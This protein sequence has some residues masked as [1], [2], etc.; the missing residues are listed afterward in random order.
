MNTFKIFCL[1]AVFSPVLSSAQIHREQVLRSGWTFSR[2]G[3]KPI[4]VVI[5]HDWAI[6]GEFDKENDIVRYETNRDGKTETVELTGLTGALPWI[7]EGEYRTTFKVSRP[8]THAELLFDGAMA[9]PEVY[10]NGSKAG[11]WAYGYNAFRVDATPFVTSD[12]KANTLTVKLRNVGQSS[13]W[14][15]GS[16]LYR[17]VKLILSGDNAID[18]WG[19]CVTTPKVSTSEAEVH[20]AV[21]LREGFS[22]GLR[23]EISVL[24]EKG[25]EVARSDAGFGN[26]GSVK[27]AVSLKFPHL[28]SPESPYLYTLRTRVIKDGKTVDENSTRFGVRW[29]SFDKEHG[30][31]FNGATRKIKGVCLHHDLGPLGAAVNKAALVRQIKIMKDMG[32]DAIRTSHNMPSTMLTDLCDS[33]GMFVMAESFDSW[34][35]GKTENAYNRFFDEWWEKDL[36][37]LILNHRNHPSIIMWSIGNEIREKERPEGAELCRRMVELCHKLDPTRP[38]T[39]GMDSDFGVLRSGYAQ[40][41]DIYGIN[42]HVGS[43]ETLIDSIPQGFILGAETS[44]DVSSRGFYK[45]PV[46]SHPQKLYPEGQ[47]SSYDYEYNTWTNTPDDD[48]WL[49]DDKPWVVGEFVWTGFDYLGEPTPYN[50]YWPSRSSYFGIVDLAGLP[51]DRFYWYRSRWNKEE[52]TVHLLPHWT[53]PGREGQV[54]PVICYSNYDEAE[55]FLNGKSQGRVKKDPSRKYG[56]YR[57][58][59]NDVKYEPGELRVVVYDKTGA[60]AGEQTVR[61]AGKPVNIV[62][63]ADRSVLRADGDDM[64]FVTVKMTDANGNECPTVSNSLRFSV[65]GAARYQAA[66]NGDATSLEP[67]ERPEMKLFNGVLVVLVRAGYKAG[68]ATLTITDAEDKSI[69]TTVNLRVEK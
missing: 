28:W 15:P 13:R 68:A 19:V 36:T 4:E 48:A 23:A 34:K 22:T 32:C 67:F 50:E 40:A 65:S 64:A 39:A 58:K 26:D 31:R 21:Q 45:F 3:E 62:A 29:F 44:S 56:R 66:C 42:Y 33:L 61:T 10:V 7:G 63:E 1:A 37:N 57:L 59:W 9:E 18:T 51:K 69:T 55:L 53:W 27:A 20:A 5:P 35:D 47:C 52:T 60:V 17:P 46:G 8:Y 38:V 43:Y 30:F 16:G 54:T 49:Q 6:S 41:L 12:G 24:D 14:Y 25:T 2:N 11:Y